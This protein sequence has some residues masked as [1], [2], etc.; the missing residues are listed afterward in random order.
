MRISQTSHEV[1]STT[2]LNMLNISLQLLVALDDAVYVS[3]HSLRL[4]KRQKVQPQLHGWE[5][6]PT[7]PETSCSGCFCYNVIFF[8]F[9]VKSKACNLH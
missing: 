8:S 7:F 3:M 6:S 4:K 9:G 5:D 2:F 1:H